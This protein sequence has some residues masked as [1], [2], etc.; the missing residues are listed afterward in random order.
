MRIKIENAN[1]TSANLTQLVSMWI[2]TK[3]SAEN[4]EVLL[5]FARS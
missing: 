5:G 3:G 4:I 2:S 1:V